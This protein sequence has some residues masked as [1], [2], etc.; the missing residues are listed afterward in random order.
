MSDLEMQM[1]DDVIVKV[2][3]G[4]MVGE[5]FKDPDILAVS[6]DNLVV[7]VY[8]R[9]VR[10]AQIRPL[11]YGVKEANEVYRRTLSF[12]LH[13]AV[14]KLF[15]N[16]RFVIGHSL[17]GGHYYD[18]YGED[19]VD[20]TMLF[21]IEEEMKR[22]IA[23]DL[24]PSRRTVSV[25]EALVMF[26]ALNRMDK[27]KLL[28]RNY[29]HDIMI[30]EL[31]GYSDIPFGPLAPTTGSIKHFS[32]SLYSPGF[33]LRFPDKKNILKMPPAVDQTRLFAV[34]HES[35]KWSRILQTSNVGDLNETVAKGRFHECVQVAEALHEKKIA[36]IADK[37][38]ANL[39]N[40]R[41][42]FI[43]GPS[44][45]GK[46]T[47]AKRLGIQ[48]RVNGV[49]PVFIS[50]DDYFVDREKTPRDAA[51][52]YDFEALEALNVEL[53]NEHLL[54]LPE[55]EEVTSPRYD[56][57]SGKSLADGHTLK[58]RNDQVLIIEGIHGLNDLLTVK[59]PRGKKFKIYV[60]ALTQLTIDDHNRIPTTDTRLIRR[61]VRDHQFRGYSAMDTIRRW[62]SVIRGE[63]R[64]IFPF[65]EE[66]DVIFNTALLYELAVLKPRARKAFEEVPPDQPEFAE[67]R[68]ILEFLHLFIEGDPRDVPPTSILREFIGGSSF[69][70]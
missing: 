1:P 51:G 24:A 25:R 46:T 39:D 37:I 22:L 64:N 23:A 26:K 61:V 4:T 14:R 28:L 13:V 70:Y 68:R 48:L 53:F 11:M 62:P 52:D 50:M 19:T 66:A 56:F 69:V 44:S 18:V 59:I 21:K 9:L 45:S 16:S 63:A 65:Q 20:G 49:H 32:L 55:G 40:A 33:V 57:K 47:F 34:Y 35:K 29:Y 58:L 7:S 10:S 5:L 60:S 17:E 42:I 38:G 43:A 41:L 30:Y 31:D 15:P 36:S 2:P 12:V 67:A 8:Y 27:V 3:V 54:R 6:V